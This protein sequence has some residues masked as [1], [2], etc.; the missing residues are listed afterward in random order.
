MTALLLL[1]AGCSGNA[2]APRVDA[3]PLNPGAAASQALATLDEN[4]DGQIAGAELD[5]APGLKAALKPRLDSNNDGKASADEITNRVQQYL[6]SR[7]ASLPCRCEVLLDGKPVEGAVV[8]FIPEPFLG[9]ALKTATG[10][11]DALG[12]T[13]LRV[14]GSDLPGMS[15]GMYRVEISKPTGGADAIPAAYRE[16]TTLGAEVANDLESLSS[17]VTF[18]LKSR[19]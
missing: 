12:V 11:T 16:K 15:P 4:K 17:G 2:P 9:T 6:N 14:E 5:K 13:M 1:T 19:P 18:S 10:T 3:A 8:R 7:V